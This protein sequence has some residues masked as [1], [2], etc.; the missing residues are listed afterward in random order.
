MGLLNFILGKNNKQW[1]PKPFYEN[2]TKTDFQEWFSHVPEWAVLDTAITDALIDK[3]LGDTQFEVFMFVS[4]EQDL[5]K[6]YIPLKQY[7]RNDCADIIIR[8]KVAS[9]L[10]HS[11]DLYYKKAKALNAKV[12]SN[13]ARGNPQYDA[14]AECLNQAINAFESAIHVE[15]RFLPPYMYLVELKQITK[16]PTEALAFCTVGLATIND[17][18]SRPIPDKMR[19]EVEQ[20]ETFLKSF[21]SEKHNL[22]VK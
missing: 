7:A 16:K 2:K 18:K 10:G 4:L 8:S 9:I 11:G 5:I 15:P 21:M 19:S 14:V 12:P 6:E 1:T 13:A 3:M 22:H 20:V 17:I